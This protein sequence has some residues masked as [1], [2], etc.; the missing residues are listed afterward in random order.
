M[1]ENFLHYIWKHNKVNASK[2][3]TTDQEALQVVFVGEHNHNTGPDFLNAQILIDEQL[4]AGNVEVHIKSSDWYIHRHEL[5]KNY[6]NVI[7]HV[8][9]LHDAEVYRNDNSTIPTLELKRFVNAITL[10]YYQKLFSKRSTWINCEHDFG[11]VDNLIIN[12]WLE[13]LYFE[14]LERKYLEIEVM[15][16]ASKNNWEDVLFKMLTKNFGLKVNGAAFL[17]LANSF[18][19]SLIQK[20]KSKSK[21][22]EALFFGQAKLLQDKHQDAY[23]QELQ[24]EYH[25]IKQKF[26]LSSQSVEPLQFF[27]LRPSN[28]PTIRLSQLARL[29]NKDSNMFSKVIK[30]KTK[31]ELYKIFNISTSK[32]WESHFTFGKTSNTRKKSITESFVNLL[33][34]NTI[35]PLQFSYAKHQGKTIDDSALVLIQQI[36][37][38]KNI[39]V[40]KYHHL[41]PVSK[42]AL[43]SQALIQLKTEYC[44]KNKCL[45]CEIGNT[46]LTRID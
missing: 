31:D 18:D 41:R 4:W 43:H 12:H 8:V 23:H 22:L 11:S 28:F 14:R 30:A 37:S 32:Y 13:R 36:S 42:T 29:Y 10:S 25:F 46:L 38:E 15:L 16:K 24:N 1:R 35:V 17:S 33:I 21:T 27:R 2:L 40:D 45:Q 39:I 19:F 9:W 3:L 7:L 34:I 6:D 20:L 26:S 5:D 44:D